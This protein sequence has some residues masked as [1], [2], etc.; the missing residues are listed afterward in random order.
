VGLLVA[1]PYYGVLPR[2][3]GAFAE[4]VDAPEIGAYDRQEFA[5]AGRKDRHQFRFIVAAEDGVELADLR[6]FT[7]ELMSTMERDLGTRLEWIAVDRW[8]TDNPHTDV[9]LRGKDDRGKDLIIA[10][11][12]LTDGMCLRAGELSSEWLG[13]RSEREIQERLQ[14]DV[15]Q[16]RWT[17]L[18]RQLQALAHDGAI[19]LAR[20]NDRADALQ[21]RGLLLFDLPLKLDGAQPEQAFAWRTEAGTPKYVGN[22]AGP[23]MPAKGEPRRHCQATS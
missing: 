10:R 13:L 8:D 23:I 18:D 15:S 16:E 1:P 7:R 20:P 17:G 21:Y 22:V 6:D 3:A 9:V 4:A 12:Y 14:R 2:I 5:A 19:N 11:S